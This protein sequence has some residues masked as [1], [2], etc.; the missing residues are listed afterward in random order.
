MLQLV[1]GEAEYYQG[2]TVEFVK[3]RTAVLTIYQDDEEIEQ[4]N[5]QDESLATSKDALHGLF[6]EKGFVVRT[7]VD[8]PLEQLIEENNLRLEKETMRRQ[9]RLEEKRKRRE[10]LNQKNAEERARHIQ[11]AKEKQKQRANTAVGDDE[12]AASASASSTGQEGAD[13]SVKMEL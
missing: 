4:I 3:G 9:A 12:S 13:E 5:L 7:D 8:K 11:E 6:Q 2:I 1:D 10:E